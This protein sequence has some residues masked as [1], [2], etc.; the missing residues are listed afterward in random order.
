MSKQSPIL[1]ATM[2][3]TLLYFDGP[4]LILLSDNSI[5]KKI[6]AI[7]VDQ[8][9]MD[10][11]MDQP[12]FACRIKGDNFEKYMSGKADLLYLFSHASRNE[13][14]F[15]DLYK[16]ENDVVKLI[17]ASDRE[18]K[19]NDFW[20]GKGIFSS[21]HNN[22]ENIN[23]EARYRHVFY[24]NGV[25]NLIDFSQFYSK[26]SDLYA[27]SYLKNL[28]NPELI[29]KALTGL[30]TPRLWTAGGS[31]F[32]FYRSLMNML[33]FIQLKVAA[34]QYASPGQIELLGNRDVFKETISLIEN[35]ERSYKETK[36]AYHSVD[37]ILTQEKLKTAKPSTDFSSDAKKEFVKKKADFILQTLEMNEHE[38]FFASCDNNVLVYS[39]LVLSI[40]RRINGI[41]NFIS[42]G[43]VEIVKDSVAPNAEKPVAHHA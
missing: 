28:K 3:D 12:F 34:I 21:S 1:S 27:I 5:H 2:I 13:Y 14:Y 35:F 43:R 42:E 37:K 8:D 38:T 19:N 4:Q 32:G 18:V 23:K 30:I 20:P 11:Y 33:D 40:Y 17:R 10:C 29:R 36:E 24:I 39:K 16:E 31:Y 7:A 26:I 41:H 22:L 15:F 6:I 25:W 9:G